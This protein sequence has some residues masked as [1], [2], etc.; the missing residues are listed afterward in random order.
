M[1]ISFGVYVYELNT[2]SIPEEGS[3]RRIYE[4]DIV[5]ERPGNVRRVFVEVN[6]GK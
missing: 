6:I 5:I 2:R 1:A 4:Q 3:R